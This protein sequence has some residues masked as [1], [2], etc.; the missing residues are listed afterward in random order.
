MP[1]IRHPNGGET[2]NGRTNST[3]D[4]D[5]IING[6]LIPLEPPT[7]LSISAQDKKVLISWT[8]PV[9]KVT[10][11]GGE[12][13]SE[14]KSTS[15]IRNTDHIPLS[16]DDGIEILKSNI[17]NAYQSDYYIDRNNISNGILY[18]YS[19]FASSNYGI[20]SNPITGNAT[21]RAAQVEKYTNKTFNTGTWEDDPTIAFSQNHLIE[22][23][24]DTYSVDNNF[25]LMSI[26]D[27]SRKR[28]GIGGSLNGYAFM[29]GGGDQYDPTLFVAPIDM[30]SPDLTR[31]SNSING[32]GKYN[33]GACATTQNHI[34]FAGGTDD[35]AKYSKTVVAT[36]INLTI[37]TSVPDLNNPTVRFGSTTNGLHAIFA[38]GSNLAYGTLED[39]VAYDDNL[40]KT[41]LSDLSMYCREYTRGTY[42]NK[43]A[44]F[45]G[46]QHS[47]SASDYVES[48]DQLLTHQILSPLSTARSEIGATTVEGFAMFVGGVIPGVSATNIVDVY[49]TSF[50]RKTDVS[51][52]FGYNQAYLYAHLAGT[53]DN[54]AIFV[55][56]C[57]RD[58][59]KSY[60]VQ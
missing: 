24:E 20:L 50:T 5:T 35:D 8:D 7:A 18:Y 43:C 38:G 40:T 10:N 36:D 57:L 13:V 44:L 4:G 9:D 17:R 22:S 25:T 46:G 55:R 19:L 1:F 33:D 23:W 34:L 41:T 56:G 42:L 6:A 53:I 26:S 47:S 51:L 58:G 30:Y 14:W 39:V 48:Y 52:E 15:I 31:T 12:M 3:K 16:I 27:N 45:A 32:E 29:Y 28:S 2:M 37:T 54:I 49:D 59:I 11:P 21:P 60:I